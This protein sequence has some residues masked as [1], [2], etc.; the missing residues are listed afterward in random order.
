[1]SFSEILTAVAAEYGIDLT[2][3]QVG[4]F[5][6]YYQL[7]TEW[8]QKVNLTAITEPEEVAVK[9]IIDSLS[10]YD[11]AVFPLGCSVI[12]VGTGAGFPGVP[13]K[14][15]RPD[16]S[17]TLLDSLNKRINFLEL[18]T[19]ELQLSE[20]SCVHA[21]AEEAGRQAK[22]RESFA[23]ATSRAVA[24]LNVLAELCLPLLKPGG[25]FIA[26]KGAQFRE[27][28]VEAEPAIALLGGRLRE[29]RPIKLPR[30][31]DSRGVIYIDKIK[32]TPAAYPRR[33]GTPEKN[34]LP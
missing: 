32:A 31:P 15:L 14:I 10:C 24:R 4:Q 11:P 13:L 29:L 5:T 18:L 16:L 21:R 12:D 3:R 30:L 27:E 23:V 33:P 2:E 19:T 34:P 1:M 8:N 7:L 26:L 22:L 25:C 9:H 28:A 20:V 17:L 6:V